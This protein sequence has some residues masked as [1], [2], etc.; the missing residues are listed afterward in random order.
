MRHMYPKGVITKIKRCDKIANREDR[1]GEA[2][3][4]ILEGKSYESRMGKKQE[5]AYKQNQV[6][7]KISLNIHAMW[8]GAG[9]A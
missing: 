1:Y 8:C 6:H 2:R 5:R 7:T 9:L 3:S 4:I